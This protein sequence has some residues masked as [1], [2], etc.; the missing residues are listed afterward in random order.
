MGPDP[1]RK[2]LALFGGLTICSAL[3]ALE[4]R[5]TTFTRVTPPLQ[6]T[7]QVT[8]EFKNTGAD[9]VRFHTIETNCDCL[10]AS[11]EKPSYAPGESGRLTA[12]FTVGDRLG[13]HH[14]SIT[15]LTSDETQPRR[16][17]V[18]LEVPPAVAASPLELFW[19][20]GEARETRTV[21]L[22]VAEGIAVELQEVLATAAGFRAL[23][24]PVV[25]GSHYRLRVTPEVIDRPLSV[26]FRIRGRSADGQPVTVSTYAHIR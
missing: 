5:S 14:R 18:E 9:V 24:E 12:R 16:L 10:E 26:A 13:T 2:A 21:D 17:T 3:P 20:V 8:F 23:L 19:N 6:R 22:R 25:A 15:V 11:V 4:W 7:V 1:W